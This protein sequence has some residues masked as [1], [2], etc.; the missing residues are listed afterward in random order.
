M[1]TD[2]YL[3]PLVGIRRRRIE[4][5]A[6]LSTI[7]QVEPPICGY[8]RIVVFRSCVGKP[9]LS[10]RAR[11]PFPIGNGEGIRRE[12]VERMGDHTALPREIGGPRAIQMAIHSRGH[13]HPLNPRVGPVQF[14]MGD[15]PEIGSRRARVGVGI[16]ARLDFLSKSEPVAIGIRIGV[17]SAFQLV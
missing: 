11:L 15:Q 7:L 1:P 3:P 9:H 14:P 13:P 12:T 5:Q 2:G 4:G 8:Y 6:A 16:G 17:R 10:H